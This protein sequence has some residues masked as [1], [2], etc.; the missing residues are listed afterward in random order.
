MLRKI[1]FVLVAL[2]L[3]LFAATAAGAAEGQ[4]PPTGGAST[5]PADPG[6]PGAAVVLLAG[7]AVAI[8]ASKRRTS[9]AA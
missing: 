2:A 7:G 8:V 9:L 4:Y 5:V 3:P 6:D 1:V